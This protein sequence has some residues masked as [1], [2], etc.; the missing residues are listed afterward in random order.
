[1]RRVDNSGSFGHCPFQAYR[2]RALECRRT[3]KLRAETAQERLPQTV[4]TGETAEGEAEGAEEEEEEVHEEKDEPTPPHETA[5]TPL[6]PRISSSPPP[7][8]SSTIPTSAS[9][10]ADFA[11]ADSSQH[12]PEGTPA[13]DDGDDG[14][15][16]DGDA[17][18]ETADGAAGSSKPPQGAQDDDNLS[19]AY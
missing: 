7:A 3:K 4:A 15:D 11:E 13:E 14:G 2:K 17:A 19:Q 18:S 8:I 5:S 6:S 12:S 1:M 10:H 16:V 9:T